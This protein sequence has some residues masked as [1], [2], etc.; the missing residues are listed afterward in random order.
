MRKGARLTGARKHRADAAVGERAVTLEVHAVH[1]GD[2]RGI[3]WLPATIE[4]VMRF[5]EE[6]ETDATP[7]QVADFVWQS[8]ANR[9]PRVMLY[10]VVGSGRVVGHLL[11]HV[12]PLGPANPPA[13]KV[14]IRQAQVDQGVDA[15][16]A[17]QEAFSRLSV[18][19]RALGMTT[20][21]AVTHKAPA[22]MLRRWGFHH[23]KHILQREIPA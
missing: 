21:S 12:D 5:A 9:D 20:F 2:E 13:S 7:Q 6:F 3:I 4:R 17:C 22:A 19:S 10:I 11:A 23:Y 1:R 16:A 8:I 15:R 18:W 14:L